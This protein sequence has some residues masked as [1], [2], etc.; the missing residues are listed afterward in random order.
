MFSLIFTR[1]KIKSKINRE[2]V[3]NMSNKEQSIKDRIA[4]LEGWAIIAKQNVDAGKYEEANEPLR[5]INIEG[6]R[7]EW[8]GGNLGL[9]HLPKME[10]VKVLKRKV[11]EARA[12]AQRA[13]IS[14]KYL[15]GIGK[16][17]KGTSKEEHFA[18][19]RKK[20][21]HLPEIKNNL[22]IL[23]EVTK[24]AN[25]I[26]K[27][28]P[29]VNVKYLILKENAGILREFF[30][31]QGYYNRL[32]YDDL[33]NLTDSFIPLFRRGFFKGADLKGI[34]LSG[35]QF[36]LADLQKADLREAKLEWIDLTEA[37]L[38]E[39]DLQRANLTKANLSGA[40]LTE[41]DLEGANLTQAELGG[42]ANLEGAN[43]EEARLEWAKNLTREQ[44]H[45]AKNWEKAKNI[46]LNLR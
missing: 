37:N 28:R 19:E 9:R 10:E 41:A 16:E 3:L 17:K 15:E 26:A 14:L 45:S 38:R 24:Q 34:N 33:K 12:A 30:T 43:L 23:I 13:M 18:R 32:G 44:L 40:D 4:S 22:A 27:D 29:W 5:S 46:P 7:V 20:A 8:R 36:K 11:S 6:R 31:R 42:G 1:I 21:Q 25:A 39:A 35:T 2:E